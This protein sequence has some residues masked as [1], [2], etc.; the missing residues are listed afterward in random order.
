VSLTP[1]TAVRI[2]EHMLLLRALDGRMMSL[3][4]QGRIGFYG[5]ALGEEAA[6]LGSI[7]AARDTDWVFPALRQGGALLWR[8]FPLEAFV[9]QLIGNTGDVLNGHQM[10]CH[11]ADRGVN[12]VAW[13]S[14]IATQLPHAVGMAFAARY[15]GKDDVALAYLG[16]GATSSPDFHAAMNFAGVWKAPVVFVCQNNHWAISVPVEVQ[17]AVKE[18]VRKADGYGV[19]G[20]R[21]DG[22]DVLAV[23]QAVR[24]AADRARRGAGPTFIECVTYRMGGHSSSDDPTRYREEAVVEEW[25]RRDPVLRFRRYLEGRGLWSEATEAQATERWNTKIGAAIQSAEAMPP[26]AVESI[27]DGVY[28]S[29]PWNLREQRDWLSAEGGGHAKDEGRFPL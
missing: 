19:P 15:K 8:G 7:A 21:V 18:L 24:A 3:Q 4:R 22:N 6:T 27:F 25:R 29:P 16:D 17:T 13:S 26:P 10:P 14:C 5:T 23:Y 9:A 11:Y 2:Y 1:E 20:V 28:A 12:V